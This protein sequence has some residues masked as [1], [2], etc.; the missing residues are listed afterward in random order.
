MGY[1]ETPAK[2]YNK[3]NIKGET[4]MQFI[5]VNTKASKAKEVFVKARAQHRDEL[6]KLRAQRKALKHDMKRHK[7]LIKQARNTYKL[8]R[9]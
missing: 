6:K 4:K 3:M 1:E 8:E 9:I 7:L 5:K 2:K